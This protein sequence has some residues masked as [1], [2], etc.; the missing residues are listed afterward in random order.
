MI[1]PNG[2]RSRAGALRL[3]ENVSAQTQTLVLP[4]N[5]AIKIAVVLGTSPGKEYELSRP[6]MTI[7][8]LGGGADIEIDD[9]E[10]SRLHCS[11]EVRRDAILLQDL[12]SKNGTYIE[13]GR[14]FASRLEETSEFQIGTTVL[15]VK[16]SPLNSA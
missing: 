14:V 11:I 5:T 3:D 10:V 9:P 12:R 8:R 4:Q 13:G 7:G 6:L 2:S 15:R 16:C 1:R